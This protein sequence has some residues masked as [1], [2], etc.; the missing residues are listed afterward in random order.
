MKNYL[1]FLLLMIPMLGIVQSVK[2]QNSWFNLEVQFD[3][4]GPSESFTLITQAGDTLVNHQP[5]VPYEFYQTLIYADSGDVEISLYDSFGDGWVDGQNTL[6][7]ITLTND[8]Q[9]TILD[10]DLNFAFTQYDTI[11]N[12]LACPPPIAGCM[13]SNS[14]NYDPNATIDDGSCL[15]NVDFSLNMN[16]YNG[17]FTTPYVVGPFNNWTDSNPMVDIY[18]NGIWET[19]IALPAGFSVWKFMLDNFA[20]QELPTNVQ[21]DPMVSCFILD[22]YGFTN[23]ILDVQNQ[24]ISLPTYCWESCYDCGDVLG[25]TDPTS[26]TY[27]PWATIDDGSCAASGPT[28]CGTD[29][30]YLKL[31]YTPDNWPNENEIVVGDPNGTIF[32]APQGTYNQSNAPAGIPIEIFICVDTNVLVD[33]TLAD[34][35]CDGYNGSTSGGSVD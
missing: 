1:K 25:C 9:G 35:Y 29:Q 22:Q 4:Y 32:Y 33:I 7:N 5:A 18:G 11:V 17:S 30:T 34:S 28:G 2:A 15:Y 31:V 27:N 14:V 13:D 16:Q 20:D 26:N 12:L 23:R 6:S 3:F 10:L 8:C 21:N 24:P 19:T